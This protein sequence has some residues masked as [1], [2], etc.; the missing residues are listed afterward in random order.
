MCGAAVVILVSLSLCHFLVPPL[1][2][3]H[4]HMCPQGKLDGANAR[5]CLVQLDFLLFLLLQVLS[6]IV[7]WHTARDTAQ[8]G[9]IPSGRR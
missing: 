6:E 4:I 7:L 9:R 1:P 2:P 3:A 5:T 8:V